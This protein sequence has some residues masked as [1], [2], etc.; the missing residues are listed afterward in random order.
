M[1]RVDGGLLVRFPNWVDFV[2]SEDGR[3]VLCTP[4]PGIPT[5]TVRHL[6]LG[7]VLP[8]ALGLLGEPALH[9][10]AVSLHGRAVGFL[11]M[12]G[13]GKST[14]AL[15]FA[16]AGWDLLGDD[17][18]VLRAVPGGVEALPTLVEARLWP[19]SVEAL[20]GFSAPL[21]AVSH[22]SRKRR[23]EV[24]LSKTR[25]A[26]QPGRLTRLFLLSPEGD[27]RAHATITR[28]E[29]RHAFECL[30]QHV[31]RLP[32]GRDAMKK[33]FEFLSR[34]AVEVPLRRLQFPRAFE[35]LPS[36]R[37]AVLADLQA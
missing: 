32:A 4:V 13:Q 18:L 27:Q 29:G 16:G 17:C 6:L 35:H 8:R 12:S 30:S 20:L 15:S 10:S 22:Y 23:V 14:L 11:G 19:D 1:T 25:L 7:Q 2:V 24:R 3:R 31:M 33:E 34:V 21:P 37:A 28:I 9:G 5:E 26:T 36:V